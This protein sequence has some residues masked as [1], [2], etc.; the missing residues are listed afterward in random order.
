MLACSERFLQ[1]ILAS[2]LG[3]V[4]PWGRKCFGGLVVGWGGRVLLC[5]P[6]GRCWRGLQRD[7]KLGRR[8]GQLVN[9]GLRVSLLERVRLQRGWRWC[10][11]GSTPDCHGGAGYR[12]NMMLMRAGVLQTG[13]G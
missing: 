3:G 9:L 5:A 7:C 6:N 11:L 2:N 12:K 1:I 4:V 13:L 8:H 10:W